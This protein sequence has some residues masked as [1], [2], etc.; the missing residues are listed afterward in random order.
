MTSIFSSTQKLFFTFLLFALICSSNGGYGRKREAEML[1]GQICR[2]TRMLGTIGGCNCS[3]IL[4]NKRSKRTYDFLVENMKSN[5]YLRPE[6]NSP[7][8]P[9]ERKMLSEFFNQ[10]KR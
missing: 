6:T 5:G 8:E 3:F 2:A 10:K 4:F 9:I 1:C 7:Q